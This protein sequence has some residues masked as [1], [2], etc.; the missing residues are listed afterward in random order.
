MAE[1]VPN[2]FNSHY[3]YL[4]HI[5]IPNCTSDFFPA[6]KRRVEGHQKGRSEEEL[7]RYFVNAAEALNNSL[8]YFYWENFDKDMHVS[9]EK[10]LK[11]A[12]K[13]YPVLATLADIANAYKHAQRNG[14]QATNPSL[15]KASQLVN[16]GWFEAYIDEY[17]LQGKLHKPSVKEEWIQSL[18]DAYQF[19]MQFVNESPEAEHITASFLQMMLK[20]QPGKPSSKV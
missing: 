15:A 1:I 11:S 16:S 13:E 2:P 8:E 20:E 6:L 14:K 4:A 7:I 10:F 17:G 9:D 3:W 18:T 5:A 12:R 19:W